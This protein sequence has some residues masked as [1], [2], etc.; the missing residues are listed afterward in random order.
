MKKE[1]EKKI[2]K[3]SELLSKRKGQWPVKHFDLLYTNWMQF[4][5]NKL[6]NKKNKKKEREKK[7]IFT[8]IKSINEKNLKK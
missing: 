8:T 1:K 2:V 6:L 3:E 5:G 7:E 4:R